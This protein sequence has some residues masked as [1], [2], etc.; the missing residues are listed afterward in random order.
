[1]H[2][3]LLLGDYDLAI[4]QL[5]SLVDDWADLANDILISSYLHFDTSNLGHCSASDCI[6]ILTVHGSLD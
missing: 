6:Q 3:C 2:V 5:K 4:Y 1:M